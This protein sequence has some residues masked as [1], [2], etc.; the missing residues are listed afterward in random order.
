ML[1][2]RSHREL[3]VWTIRLVP[4]KLWLTGTSCM[5]A[6]EIDH[7]LFWTR[8]YMVIRPGHRIGL[9]L[10]Y[11][12]QAPRTTVVV[13][14]WKTTFT[15]DFVLRKSG[16]LISE[17]PTVTCCE[18]RCIVS[19]SRTYS[20]ISETILKLA[21]SAQSSCLSVARSSTYGYC[22]IYCRSCACVM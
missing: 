17:I 6:A 1:F 10:H 20:C 3:L 19:G 16:M 11:K 4:S 7:K 18:I 2:L 22:I 13:L 14:E 15:F 21:S 12:M 8:A 9:Q 5:I